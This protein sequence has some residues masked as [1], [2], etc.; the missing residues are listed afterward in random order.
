L[1][2][3]E[4][5]ASGAA[6]AASCQLGR[7]AEHSSDWSDP[8]LS[9]EL[10]AENGLATPT[11]VGT[12]T[13]VDQI[14]PAS[15]VEEVS[16]CAAF[17]VVVSP[18]SVDLIWRAISN[19]RVGAFTPVDVFDAHK[20]IAPMARRL[21]GSQI[22][23]DRRSADPT[24]VVEAAPAEVFVVES[25]RAIDHQIEA[26]AGAAHILP[27]PTFQVV[28][29]EATDEPVPISAAVQPALKVATAAAQ[30]QIA[31]AQAFDEIVTT[32]ALSLVGAG[33]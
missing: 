11:G 23:H 18:E 12:A 30:D 7:A 20:R 33:S 6:P 32:L 31:A 13:A 5:A 4:G 15:A 22:D 25:M 17:N 26:R 3:V 1:E 8:L 24:D 16:S 9:A 10:A 29:S 19:Q 28:I 27:A 2:A 21:S 14:R